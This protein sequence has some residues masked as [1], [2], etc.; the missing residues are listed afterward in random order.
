MAAATRSGSPSS[1]LWGRPVLIAQNPQLRVQ[2]S[3]KIIKV[4]VRWL[5]HSPML[6]HW[7]LSHTVLSCKSASR[8]F[9]AM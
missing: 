9:R 3:P 6:G 2:T 7:A 5:Q 8:F 1:S 4:A